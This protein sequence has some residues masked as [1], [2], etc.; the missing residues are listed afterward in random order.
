MEILA[1]GRSREGSEWLRAGREW[2]DRQRVSAAG[3]ETPWDDRAEWMVLLRE[4]EAL[5]G[6]DE[7]AAGPR[8]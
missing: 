7:T 6:G 2:I 5:T 4:A 3:P 1:L 8:R